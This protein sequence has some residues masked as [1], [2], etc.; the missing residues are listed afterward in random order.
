MKK[1]LLLS[2]IV[3]L[4]ACMSSPLNKSVTEPMSV[5]ELNQVIK[6][7]ENFSNL[8]E[9]IEKVIKNSTITEKAAYADLTY[10]RV[11]DFM[12]KRWNTNFL[13][14][15]KAEWEAKFGPYR[16]YER[17][18]SMSNYW[19]EYVNVHG[20][21]SAIP[22]N[23]RELWKEKDKGGK[24]GDTGYEFC[25]ECI[26]KDEFGCEEYCDLFMYTAEYEKRVIKEWDELAASFSDYLAKNMWK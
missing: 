2:V 22:Y 15:A 4:T 26:V 19:K 25:V 1:L 14:E 7:C 16:F 17:V 21:N 13:E 18:D 10:K 11:Y 20:Q 5:E 9:Q 12:Y 3:L 24:K 8:Y 6:T 23:I